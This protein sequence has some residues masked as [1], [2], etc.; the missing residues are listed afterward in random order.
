MLL[1][2]KFHA[3]P[4]ECHHAGSE[5]AWYG[6]AMPA[7][8]ALVVEDE[9][10][11]RKVV[12]E[13]L[14]GAGYRV[15]LCESGDKAIQ[16]ASEQPFD[17][18]I[19]DVR[20]GYGPDGLDVLAAVQKHQAQTPVILM[21]AF[22]DVENAM[23]A[24]Q[25][26]AYDYISKFPF[27]PQEL[28][29][30]VARSLERRRLAEEGRQKPKEARG[31]I[32][33][34]VGRSP[35]MLEVYKLVARVASSLSTVL[36][37]GESGTGKELV[38]RAIHNHSTRAQGP[39]VAVNCTAISESLLESEL[40]GHVKGAFTG[41][42]HSKRGYFEESQGGTLFLDEIGDINAKMQAQLLARSAR[43]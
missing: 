31:K 10:Q 39:F 19:S 14:Q 23:K 40:F 36:V 33:E 5:R 2:S 21:T 29:Q 16:L 4:L 12:G 15:T 3:R 1:R 27:Q 18:I 17:V 38:A 7:S 20:L 32:R 34:I 6:A 28:L 25:Q 37:V 11:F 8:H 35:A 13:F 9:E 42:Q 26:G 22:G 41:A 43:G 30:C 24:I